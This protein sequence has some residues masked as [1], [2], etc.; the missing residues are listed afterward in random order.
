M[1][2]VASV[3]PSLDW[4]G[5]IA[6]WGLAVAVCLGVAGG[7]RAVAAQ[8]DV[9]VTIQTS[10]GGY[11]GTQPLT[12]PI[13]KQLAASENSD[14]PKKIGNALRQLKDGSV[15]VLA[16]HSNPKKFGMGPDI[17]EWAQFWSTFGVEKPPRLAAVIIGGCMVEEPGEDK[18]VPITEDQVR[19]LRRLFN[20]EAIYTPKGAVP[21]IMAITDTNG[22]LASLL[23]GKKLCDINLQD[24][25]HCA[26]CPRW[27][28]KKSEITLK[29]LRSFG[30]EEDAYQ[31]GYGI[32]VL[33]PSQFSREAMKEVYSLYNKDETLRE[34]FMRG[35]REGSAKLKRETR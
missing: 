10:R 8:A 21:K 30:T 34:S 11:P 14:D 17:V 24:R 16:V 31:A 3:S 19:A 20:A 15:L 22:M 5:R 6:A 7:R 9:G 12:V 27:D 18:Y 1:K 29:E 26:M 13:T 25:W 33:P 23:K 28:A 2:E 4:I 32:G 35:Y